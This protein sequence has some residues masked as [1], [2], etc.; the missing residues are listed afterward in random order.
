VLHLLYVICLSTYLFKYR[1]TVNSVPT[2]SPFSVEV[3]CYLLTSF[4]KGSVSWRNLS[5]LS[6][7]P[8]STFLSARPSIFLGKKIGTMHTCTCFELS[9]LLGTKDASAGNS[10]CRFGLRHY[11]SSN[12]HTALLP[13]QPNA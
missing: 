4:I 5:F 8:I 12:T 7:V 3:C 6:R 10:T 11:S 1:H 2:C 13:S 9:C